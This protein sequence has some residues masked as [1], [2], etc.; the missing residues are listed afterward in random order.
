MTGA[1]C[2]TWLCGAFK[3][4]TQKP[5]TLHMSADV[6]SARTGQPHLVAAAQQDRELPSPAAQHIGD[7]GL[8]PD[9][10]EKRRSR[11]VLVHNLGLCQLHA[12]DGK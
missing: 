11:G 2:L 9:S 6:A 5:V 8:E 10:L 3:Q 7:Q 4:A 1:S 12:Q